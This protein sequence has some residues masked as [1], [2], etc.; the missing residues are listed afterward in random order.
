MEAL[1]PELQIQVCSYLPRA[2]LLT[3]NRTCTSLAAAA[4]PL[5]FETLIF[6]GDDHTNE[7]Q[8][9]L[10]NPRS[11]ELASLESAVDRVRG[12]G[13]TKYVK[14]FQYSPKIYVEGMLALFMIIRIPLTRDC[15]VLVGVSRLGRRPAG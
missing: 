14:T 11:V 4:K 3:I 12:L 1:P 9:P 5:L 6:H 8:V 10:R 13:I 15:R 2:D 7:T